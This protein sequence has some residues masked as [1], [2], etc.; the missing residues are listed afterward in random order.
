MLCGDFN[1]PDIDWSKNSL[2]DNPSHTGESRMLLETMAEF[3]LSQLASFPTR[4]SNTL[5]LIMANKEFSVGDIKSCPGVSDHDMI[6]LNFFVKPQR[7]VSRTRKIYLYPKTNLE[8]LKQGL[9]VAYSEMVSLQTHDS[10]D[11]LWSSF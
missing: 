7:S 5:D 10:V 6:M 3:G 9:N 1:L 8:R 4:Q 2:R 11:N